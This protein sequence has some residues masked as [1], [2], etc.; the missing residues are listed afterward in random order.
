MNDNI[1]KTRHVLL[2]II[3]FPI[4]INWLILK[5]VWLK[6]SRLSWHK[7]AMTLFSASRHILMKY[8]E[9]FKMS[10]NSQHVQWAKHKI[11]YSPWE[12]YSRLMSRM[13]LMQL[14]SS[15]IIII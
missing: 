11:I 7:E 12:L 1:N 5:I 6:Q 4:L 9:V 2:S 3:L 8:A 13:P 15:S 14:W 10:K